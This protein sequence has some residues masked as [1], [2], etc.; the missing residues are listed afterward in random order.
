MKSIRAKILVS[1]L[2]V[3]VAAF[4]VIGVITY[5]QVSKNVNAVTVDLSGQ[6]SG[7]VAGQIDEVIHALMNRVESV[8]STMRARSMEWEQVRAA[9][10][11]LSRSES[12]FE[13]GILAWPDGRVETTDGV[14]TDVSDRSYFKAIFEQGAKYAV[15]EALVSRATGKPAFVIAFPVVDKGQTVGLIGYTVS[16]DKIAE[17]TGRFKPLGQGYV[18]LVDNTGTIVA[19]PKANYVMKLK[20]SEADSQGFTGLSTIAASHLSGKSGVTDITDPNGTKMKVFYAPLEYARGW[21]AM[22][23][24]PAS[25][26][27]TIASK[28]EIP[29]IVTI[30][31]ALVL[32]SA[33]IFYITSKTTRPLSAITDS[34]EQFG[35]GNLN[36]TFEAKTEDEVGRIASACKGAVDRIEQVVAETFNISKKNKDTSAN[37]ASATR[38]IA[39]SLQSINKSMEEVY[40]SAENNSAATEEASASIEEIA[41]GAQSSAQSATEAA[42]AAD[43][44]MDAV[45]KAN[46]QMA[47]C[48]RQLKVVQNMSNDSVKKTD[49]LVSSLHSI[50]D[51][52]D[53]ITGIADQ[54]NLLAL[55]AAIEAARAGEEGRGFAVVAE[56]VRKLAEQ[57]SGAAQKIRGLM[58]ELDS[59]ASSTASTINETVETT[60]KVIGA[61]EET[62]KTLEGTTAQ[63]SKI[64]ESIQSLASIAEEQS[65]STEEMASATSQIAKDSTRIAELLENI[66]ATLEEIEKTAE[67]IAGDAVGMDEGAKRLEKV[68]SFFKSEKVRNS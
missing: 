47:N 33:V 24:I 51:F 63:V 3:I 43:A 9:L 38:Q 13:S 44:A 8:A 65:A 17:I 27:V 35:E 32:V 53:V 68:L 22:L 50:T 31:V 36:V 7:A 1:V 41:S 10:L 23:Y 25:V 11:D 28:S 62:Q 20:L 57:S 4:V 39:A 2:S 67:S 56:E 48:T 66:R 21:S 26:L 19:H 42:E 29:V 58:A 14:S 34:V 49:Y 15:S 61:V 64:N 52:V 40:A 18:S 46:Q 60:I 12:F 5:L 55:N 45:E 30:L 59:N 6:I 54:T 37:M 16:I